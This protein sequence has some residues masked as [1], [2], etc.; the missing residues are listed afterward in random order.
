MVKGNPNLT[1]GDHFGIRSP[2]SPFGNIVWSNAINEQKVLVSCEAENEDD[3]AYLKGIQLHVFFWEITGT[4]WSGV[5]I[6][7]VSTSVIYKY[8]TKL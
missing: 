3:A 4:N 8:A 6:P 7:K 1:L 2:E 5:T